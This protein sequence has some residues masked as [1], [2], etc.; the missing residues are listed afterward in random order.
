VATPASIRSR[1]FTFSD[2]DLTDYNLR[3][4]EKELDLERSQAQVDNGDDE[5]HRSGSFK[6]QLHRDSTDTLVEAAL[7][8]PEVEERHSGYQDHVAESAAM[9]HRML[10][11]RV[12]P[13]SN[14]PTGGGSVLT[15]LMKLEA[16]R[17]KEEE[18]RQEKERKRRQKK[19]MIL[20]NLIIH[21]FI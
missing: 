20:C 5:D 15:S 12:G 16:Q 9:V 14:I 11:T 6:S 18:R 13:N 19:V 7:E 17:Q 1:K 3:K 21:I 4:A 8:K 10:S 2:E